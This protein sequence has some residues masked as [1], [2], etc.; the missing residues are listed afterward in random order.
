MR[1]ALHPSGNHAITPEQYEQEF[2][3]P[4]VG[5]RSPNS[6]PA[7][8]CPFC[9]IRLHLRGETSPL[10]VAHFSHPP[11]ASCPSS[12]ETGTPYHALTPSHPDLARARS[13]YDAFMRSWQVHF[14]AVEKLVPCLRGAEFIELASAATGRKSW[15]YVD[16]AIWAVPYLLVL[17]RDFPPQQPVVGQALSSARKLYFRFWFHHERQNLSAIWIEGA[18]PVKLAR[19]AYN[20]P[21]GR[22][23]PDEMDLAANNPKYFDVGPGLLEEVGAALRK[24]PSGLVAWIEKELPAFRPR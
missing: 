23:R 4:V 8:R 3:H 5:S 17:Q 16:Q 9:P 10:R 22:K 7:P 24:L 12:A 15:S 2:G 14:R 20:L 21:S 18:G 19:A 13:L 1:Y 11:G 6:R